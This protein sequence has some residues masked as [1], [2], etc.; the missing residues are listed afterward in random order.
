MAEVTHRARWPFA[1]ATFAKLCA[2]GSLR[3][4]QRVFGPQR[5]LQSTIFRLRVRGQEPGGQ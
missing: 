3:P 5:E 4:Y 2:C 1:L